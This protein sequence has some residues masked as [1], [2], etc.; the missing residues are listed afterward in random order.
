VDMHE[1][2]I[3]GVGISVKVRVQCK[4]VYGQLEIRKTG[5]LWCGVSDPVQ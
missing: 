1:N 4:Q 5:C 2:S 3:P